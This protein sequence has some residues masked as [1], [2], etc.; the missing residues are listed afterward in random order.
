[1]QPDDVL[2]VT[3]GSGLVGANLV[4]HLRQAGF[5]KVVAPRQEDC[6]F[7]DRKATLDFFAAARPVY[8]FHMAGYVRGI[9]GNMRHQAEAW[10]NNTLINT[11]VV[12]ASHKAGVKKI[13]AMGT[14]AMYPDPLPSNPLREDTI[15]QGAPHGSE[16]GYAQAKRGML[17]Q[18]QVY[19]DSY[20][21]DY[22]CVLST[23]LYGPHDRFDIETGHVVPSLI[24]KFYDAKQGGGTVT[25]WGDGSAQ[26]DFIYVKDAA[27][28]LQLIM[29]KVSGTVNLATGVTRRIREAVDILAAHTGLQDRV[30]WDSSKPN[31]QLFRAYDVSRLQQAGFACQSTLEQALAET[32]DWYAAN[33]LTARH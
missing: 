5:T 8:V 25:V 6:D 21:L 23:N 1:M 32:Y 11:H 20:G 33:A 29:D 22:A 19:N 24:K 15:W 2:L 30:V 12:E 13:V 28:A 7:T 4:A 10:L 31:G 26:R 27:R 18:L 9:M 17:A 3:G 14:V 16:Y